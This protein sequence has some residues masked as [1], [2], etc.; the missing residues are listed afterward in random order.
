M[1]DFVTTGT[2]ASHAYAW[3][4]YHG[5]F[6]PE[7]YS[8]K[9]NV[10]FYANTII[11]D[12]SNTDW[13][14]EISRMGDTIKINNIPN[15]AVKD[16]N[17]NIDMEEEVPTPETVEMKIDR[18]KYTFVEI[19]ELMKKQ[20]HIDMETKFSDDASKQLKISVEEDCFLKWLV[21]EG[22]D[23][24]NKGKVAGQLSG[25]YNMGTSDAPVAP[26]EVYNTIISMAS[27][28]DEQDVPSSD[29]YLVLTPNVVDLLMK[30]SL[31]QAQF[32]GDTTNI[33]RTGEIGRLRHFTVY[34]STLLP[35]GAAGKALVSGRTALREGA[36]LADA[37]K[38]QLIFA[39]HKSALSFAG[40]MNYTDTIKIPKKIGTYLRSLYV[41]G[42]KVMKP[43]A[44]VTALIAI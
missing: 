11:S 37:K 19:S 21:T 39:G 4:E 8:K 26:D 38:R 43:T 30:S 24:E 32:T 33:V 16:Y 22:A 17:I 25:K 15:I 2:G 14:G 29:R 31:A 34:T 7:L 18:G 27:V 36:A 9:V 41:Y 5:N 10:K 40:Q 6:I 42:M 35:M 13:E 3:G 12:I 44:L 20:S 28:L 1:A 23:A